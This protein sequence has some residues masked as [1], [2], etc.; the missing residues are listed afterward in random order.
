MN[1]GQAK[2][3]AVFLLEALGWIVSLAWLVLTLML[4]Q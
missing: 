1:E 4:C 3:A 2:L